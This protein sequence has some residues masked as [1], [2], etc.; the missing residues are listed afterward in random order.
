[1]QTFTD[2]ISSAYAYNARTAAAVHD[3]A[4]SLN[5]IEDVHECKALAHRLMQCV[6]PGNWWHETEAVDTRTGEELDSVYGQYWR[7][8]SR[9]CSSCTS[10]YSRRNRRKLRDSLRVQKLARG[11]RYYFLT[12]TIQNPSLTIMQTRKLV[13]IA[14]QLMTKRS[15]WR[16]LIR[17]GCKSEEFTVTPNGYHYHV[18]SLVRSKWILFQELRRLWTDCVEEAFRREGVPFEVATKDGFLWL[19][20]KM[21]VDPDHAVQEVAKYITKSDSWS[22][23][24]PHVMA[25]I[26]LTPR[27]N[28]MFEL[29]GSFRNITATPILDT[30]NIFHGED[31]PRAQPWREMVRRIGFERYSHILSV[32]IA[33]ARSY[34]MAE[35]GRRYAK[36]PPD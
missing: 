26:A 36:A 16:D 35:L 12:F 29:F 7:C 27:W 2:R 1:M 3:A 28:R 5:C 14:W 20:A 33:D 18:H 13:N 9:L 31:V 4:S 32:Q 24:P 30:G 22:K 17:G 21:L 8:G 6:D 23:V 25:E 15:V 34:R 10:Y 19:K 11:E